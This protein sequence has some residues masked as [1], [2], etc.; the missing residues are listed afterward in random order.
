MSSIAVSS[1]WSCA[2]QQPPKAPKL[3]VVT[4][5]LGVGRAKLA[6][7]QVGIVFHF[8]LDASPRKARMTPSI[9][10]ELK[11][12]GN[13]FFAMKSTLRR[14][15]SR[16][17]A[18][19]PIDLRV[20]GSKSLPS[21]GVCPSSLRG[22]TPGHILNERVVVSSSQA[23]L[24]GTWSIFWGV[25]LTELDPAYERDGPASRPSLV[26]RPSMGLPR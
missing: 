9:A 25:S 15:R 12:D 21:G 24:S 2:R 20:G 22:C 13:A 8:A 7:G 10:V 3:G 26:T 19:T 23:G 4:C 18:R 11:V 16:S 6:T 1:L 5:K 17:M 14:S